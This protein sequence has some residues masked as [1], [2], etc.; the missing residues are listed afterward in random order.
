MNLT[1]LWIDFFEI[2]QFINDFSLDFQYNMSSL[3]NTSIISTNPAM[4]LL[5]TTARKEFLSIS[6]N[7]AMSLKLA[8]HSIQAGQQT[9]CSWPSYGIFHFQMPYIWIVK[10]VGVTVVEFG[11]KTK[12]FNRE[13]PSSNHKRRKVDIFNI[14]S[15]PQSLRL[16][17]FFSKYKINEY[18]I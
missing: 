16:R 5:F 1:Y 3:P 11:S 6:H 4:S 7:Q 12:H 10:I 15:L 2:F 17:V 8:V 13:A 18:V 9:I 14:T